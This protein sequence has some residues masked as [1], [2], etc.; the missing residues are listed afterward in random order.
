MNGSKAFIVGALLV[1][2][3]LPVHAQS[4]TGG[5]GSDVFSASVD[6]GALSGAPARFGAIL[7]DQPATK[8]FRIARIGADGI[9][10]DPER[11]NLFPDRNFLATRIRIDRRGPSDLTWFGR[12]QSPAGGVAIL[13]IR[14]GGITATIDAGNEIYAVDPIGG[15][16]HIIR[17]LDQAKYPPDDPPLGVSVEGGGTSSP[18]GTTTGLPPN[19][20]LPSLSDATP[21]PAAGKAG[22]SCPP[23]IKVLV[24]YTQK[25]AQMQFNLPAR[26]QATVDD[27]QLIYDNS[28]LN[29]RIELAAAIQV[30]YAE[31]GDFNKDL[32]NFRNKT[33]GY[34]DE[35]HGIR[36]DR[37]ADVAMLVMDD[38]QYCGLASDI[39]ATAST[40]FAAVYWQCLSPNLSFAHE[41]GHLQG[42]RH[43]PEVDP[44]PWPYVY[45]HGYRNDAAGW[46]TVMSYD[47]PNSCPRIRYFANPLVLY[48]G[49]PTGLPPLRADAL[50]LANTASSVADFFK[51]C[52]ASGN[53]SANAS[54]HRGP[55]PRIYKAGNEMLVALGNVLLKIAGTGGTGQNMF[56]LNLQNGTFSGVPG[57]NYFLGSQTFPAP[58]A[59]VLYVNGQTLVGLTDGRLVKVSGTGGTGQNMFAINVH[60]AGFTGIAGY[61]YYIGSHKF[62]SPIV[63]MASPWGSETL[64]SFG[65]G[66]VLK[67]SGTGGSGFNMM[68]IQETA[69]GFNGLPGY[70]YYIGDIRFSSAVVDMTPIASNQLLFS[71]SGGKMLKTLWTG[72]TG[73]NMLAVS[74]TSGG[75]NGLPGYNYYIGDAYVSA[76]VSDVTVVGGETLISFGNGKVL[77]IAG[78][79]GTG[80]NMFAVTETSGGFNGLPGYNYYIGDAKF[81]AAVTDA[82]S[83]SGVTLLGLGNGKLLK[84]QGTGGTGHNMF[85][86]TE[87]SNGF[88]TVPGYNYLLGSSAFGTGVVGIVEGSGG[89]VFLSFQNGK[90]F[91]TKNSGGTGL[92]AFAVTQTSD[93]FIPLCCYDYWA[94]SY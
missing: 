27:T 10:P 85:A 48:G 79:G 69:S 45:G 29:L 88:Q 71:L 9:P 26:I 18:S 89:S 87:T 80:H 6:W 36:A 74:E 38:S 31:T 39:K 73:H 3:V 43:N 57:Y 65:N 90:M 35:I 22:S 84:V 49:Q 92:N 56:A 76:A 17:Q 1:F 32:K 50:A 75:F 82:L 21:A 63:D 12:I 30:T 78:S 8:R 59:D 25:A 13:V 4:P 19:A 53:E 55:P 24:A 66:K 16:F 11:L 20:A 46:R 94:G 67:V 51:D 15:G 86:V 5:R 72:G 2:C 77:K 62:G 41:I 60:N 37:G 47:C 83:M 58:I 68:A 81:S 28:N 70:A 23:V 93:A 52:A 42:A 44:T 33:D 7:R 34:M 91:K 64:I 40:A 14:D 54:S 61:P